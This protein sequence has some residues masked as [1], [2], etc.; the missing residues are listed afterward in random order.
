MVLSAGTVPA[1]ESPVAGVEVPAWSWIV[2]AFSAAVI[3]LVSL[4][5]GAVLGSAAEWLHEFA[6]DGRHFISVPCH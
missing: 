5:N 6:H 4:E 3:Y 2:V 1:P